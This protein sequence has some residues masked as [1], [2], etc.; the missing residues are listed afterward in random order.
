M[1]IRTKAVHVGDRKKPGEHIPV[2]TPIYTASSFIYEDQRVADEVF[3]GDRAGYVYSRHEN[4]TNVAL[5]ELVTALES[6]A[7]ALAASSGMAALHL[8]LTAALVDRPKRILAASA[9]YG[10]TVGMLQK[11]MEPFGVEVEWVDI[12]EAAAVAEAASRFRPGSILMETVSNPLL[13]M[14]PLDRIGEIARANGAALV[15][16][17]TFTTPM[18]VRPLELGA[19]LVVH[20]ATKYLSG[21]GDV[22]GGFVVSDPEHLAAVRSL[23]RS[24]GPVMGP[25]EAYLSMR[26]IKTFP[27]RMERQC[28]NAIAV[29][30]WLTRHPKVERVHFNGDPAHPDAATVARLMPAGLFGAIVAFEIRGADREGV[31]DFMNRL[32]LVVPATSLG[33]V[34]SMLLYPAMASHREIAPKQR[35]KMGI[36]ENLV[37]LSVGIEAVEDILADLSNALTY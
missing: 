1:D 3:A 11:A 13:R 23:A 17:N 33:D 19:H 14:G 15:V 26:G 37:R 24:Y 8:A 30:E 12:C 35:L 25:F 27:L 31:F 36:R 22:L 20:S 28:A 4:P 5:E 6:G 10:A 21:H 29:A 34:H 7:G 9:I 2:A 16:D 32:R 18:L